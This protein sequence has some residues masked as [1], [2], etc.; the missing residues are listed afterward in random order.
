MTETRAAP[1]LALGRVRAARLA[2]T[3]LRVTLTP[4]LSGRMTVRGSP[5][6]LGRTGTVR[7]TAL[8]GR[9]K[10]VALPV[11][12]A[13]RKRSRRARGR[14]RLALT[15]SIAAATARATLRVAR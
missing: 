12:K 2:G 5:G 9:A 4:P 13:V 15:A 7:T 3:K 11:S 1:A 6:R 10:T 8:A 14:A